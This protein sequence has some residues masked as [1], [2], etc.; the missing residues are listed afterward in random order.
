MDENR[1]NLFGLGSAN[2][3]KGQFR[4]LSPYLNIDPSYLQTHTP[5]FIVDNE[6]KRGRLENSFSA[7]GSALFVGAAAGGF[8]GLFDGVRTTAGMSGKLK[9]TQILNHTLKSGKANIKF[10]QKKGNNS[11]NP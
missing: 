11:S 7:I 1:G 8:Y 10:Y 4:Q 6:M 2:A 5:E 3:Q 9:R